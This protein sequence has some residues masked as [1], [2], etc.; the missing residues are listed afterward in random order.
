MLDKYP[1]LRKFLGEDWIKGEVLNPSRRKKHPLYWIISKD[2]PYNRTILNDL[3]NDLK[4]VLDVL[5]D[6][7]EGKKRLEDKLKNIDTFYST[8]TEIHFSA[9]FY[10]KGFPVVIEPKYPKRG[11]DFKVKVD[12]RDIYFEI[13]S[14]NAAH[15]EKKQENIRNEIKHQ[16]ERIKSKFSIGFTQYNPLKKYDI[17]PI[18]KAIKFKLHRLEKNND[19]QPLIMYYA[20]PSNIKEVYGYN[21]LEESGYR[22]KCKARITLIPKNISGSTSVNFSY[23][24]VGDY[25]KKLKKKLGKKV[26]DQLQKD[27]PNIVIVDITSYPTKI[28]YTTESNVMDAIY[29]TPNLYIDRKTDNTYWFREMDGFFNISKR[30]S[31]IIVYKWKWDCTCIKDKTKLYNDIDFEGIELRRTPLTDKEINLIRKCLE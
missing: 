13:F 19:K 10:K 31:A 24:I 3:E 4:V 12:R 1:I 28:T 27:K 21:R 7:V 29:G 16:L 8:L 14:I 6:D 20:S 5:N 18:V 11:P 30:I 17:N 26:N 9:L 2:R 23:E 22:N 15:E 25:T